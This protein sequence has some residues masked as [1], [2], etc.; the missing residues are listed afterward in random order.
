MNSEMNGS[1]YG[2]RILGNTR[3]S[4]STITTLN[5]W[6]NIRQKKPDEDTETE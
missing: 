6:N 1:T 3:I 2:S 4:E 5:P